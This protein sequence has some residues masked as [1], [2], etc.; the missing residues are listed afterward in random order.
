MPFR[1]EVSVYNA[2]GEV[3]R[4]LYRGAARI[5]PGHISLDSPSLSLGQASL[6]I[7]VMGSLAD[8]QPSLYWDGANDSGQLVSTGSYYIKMD[9]VDPFG[10]TSSAIVSVSVLEARGSQRLA[11]YNS[12][13]ELM[14][15][16]ELPQGL[17]LSGFELAEGIL[18]LGGEAPA[19][20]SLGIELRSGQNQ[21]HQIQWDGKNSRGDF[22]DS[23]VYSIVLLSRKAG[24]ETRVF[25]KDVQVLRAPMGNPASGAHALL[26]PLPAGRAAF[27]IAYPAHPG[28]QASAVLYSLSGERVS[29]ASAPGGQGI[30]LIPCNH[31]GPGIY[32]ARLELRDLN[33]Q[34]G[35]KTIKLALIR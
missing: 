21:V 6:R 2:A 1:I 31:L 13:G 14:R 29:Q 3:V 35:R 12:A 33:G 32:L 9:S 7:D 19:P 15:S 28:R 20:K 34:S 30:L 16:M 8:G 10:A 23:G 11:V 5:R 18:L 17:E 4:S 24:S 27:S 22:V 25:S 26:N